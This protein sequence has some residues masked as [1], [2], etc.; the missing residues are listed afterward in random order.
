[1]PATAAGW[2]NEHDP[3]AAAG[4]H[5]Q[6]AW[7][8]GGH[9]LNEPV[10]IVN[11]KAQI[12]EVNQEYA[13][14]APSG[15]PLGYIRQVGQSQAKQVM[16]ALTN[17][18]QYMT[19][20]LDILDAHHNFVLR[21]TRPA[22]FMKSRVIVQGPEGQEI[23]QIVQKNVIGKIRFEFVANGAFVGSIN[24]ENWR[25]WN[26]R[27]EDHTGA[28]VARITKTWEGFAKTMFTTADNYVVQIHRP[29]H[30]PLRS[31]VVAAA[32]AVDVALKQD[33][34]GFS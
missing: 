17:V 1:M 12:F 7:Q 5:G 31:L 24:A 22:K 4:A 11:Q 34:R 6:A 26:F 8:G 18:D 9:L 10:L 23:G 15:A 27:I 19:H 25:A 21:V 20:H 28:E 3:V 30:D 2:M 13:I 29:L 14:R 33:S 16:R 32:S